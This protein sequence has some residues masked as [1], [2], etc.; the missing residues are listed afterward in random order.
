MVDKAT[1]EVLKGLEDP[2]VIDVRDPNEVAEG[3]GGPPSAI[4][5][6]V[7][8]CST[9]RGRQE[10]ERLPH[11]AGG[12]PSEAERCRGDAATEGEGDHHTLRHWGPRRQ[13]L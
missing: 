9:E 7:G 2:L 11:I 8:Q 3:K 4:P 12:I 6:S 1:A 5:G 13:S 10:T